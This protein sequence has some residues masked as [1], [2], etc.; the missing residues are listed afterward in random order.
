MH[1]EHE[2]VDGLI[3]LL[4]GAREDFSVNPLTDE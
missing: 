3:E 4:Y 2:R 1:G